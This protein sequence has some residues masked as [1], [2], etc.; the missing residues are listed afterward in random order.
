VNP[1]RW[2]AVVGAA[3]FVFGG[4]VWGLWG[5]LWLSLFGVFAGI[6]LWVFGLL[7][8]AYVHLLRAK[9]RKE[10]H[11]PARSADDGS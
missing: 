11:T 6:G 1:W 7:I 3:L 8:W 10:S 5:V 2:C 4:L 9:L